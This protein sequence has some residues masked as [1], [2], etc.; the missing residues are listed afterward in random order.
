MSHMKTGKLFW[1]LMVFHVLGELDVT[2]L[3]P[4]YSRGLGE[5]CLI[6]VSCSTV[7]PE[8]WF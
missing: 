7:E 2:N 4:L 3:Q 5:R 8:G 6:H 1:E